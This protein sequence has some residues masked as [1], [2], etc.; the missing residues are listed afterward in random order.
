MQS[1]DSIQYVN[2]TLPMIDEEDQEVDFA[3]LAHVQKDGSEYLIALDPDDEDESIMVF[4]I[5]VDDDGEEV[6]AVVDD[7]DL[8]N[9]IYLLY[10]AHYED[11]EIGPAK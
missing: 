3:V 10:D 9:Q 4:E 6:F 7:M 11:Y 1:T 8:A 2:E 5:T